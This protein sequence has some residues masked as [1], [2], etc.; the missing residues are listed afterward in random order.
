MAGQA[1]VLTVG[2]SAAQGAQEYA[3]SYLELHEIKADYLMKGG[4]RDI[5]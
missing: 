4:P 3:R 5:S 1:Y 2:N